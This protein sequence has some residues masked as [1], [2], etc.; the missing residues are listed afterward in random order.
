M[1]AHMPTA[2]ITGA[3]SGIGAE[4][5]RQFHAQGMRVVL[6]ARRAERL[7][8][9]C[10]ELNRGRLDSAVSIIADL[11]LP[12]SDGVRA[13][14]EFVRSNSIDVL[15]NNA[16]RGSFGYFEELP[17]AGELEMVALNISATLRLLH[18]ALPRMKQR[19][20]GIVISVSSIAAFQPL[21]F[22][23]TYA[24]TKAFNLIHTLGLRF[25][26]AQF[27]IKALAVCPG[28]TDTEFGGV[29]RVPGKLTGV[30]RDRVEDVVRASMRALEHGESY[31]VT[32][33]RWKLLRALLWLLPM[34]LTTWFTGRTLYSTLRAAREGASSHRASR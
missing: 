23:A 16:G 3:S 11:S 1:K 18:A 4:F 9:L 2:V 26:L 7:S 34:P 27:N 20:S 22:M 19:R 25:E 32:G 31:V 14:E 24:A 28:P 21:P 8:A 15:V 30:P 33:T 17:V 13:L 5:A 29:A 10:D 12:E 6:V